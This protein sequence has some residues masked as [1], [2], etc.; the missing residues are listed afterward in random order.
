MI[1][2]YYNSTLNFSM[3]CDRMT[4]VLCI[5]CGAMFPKHTC[6]SENCEILAAGYRRHFRQMNVTP[7]EHYL[8][9]LIRRNIWYCGMHDFCKGHNCLELHTN[10]HGYN[11]YKYWS[12]D[13]HTLL[14]V[15]CMEKG[16]YYNIGCRTYAVVSNILHRGNNVVIYNVQGAVMVSESLCEN[17]CVSE[18]IKFRAKVYCKDDVTTGVSCDHAPT[19]EVNTLEGHHEL[20]V[21]PYIKKMFMA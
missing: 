5:A 7:P 3:Q 14:D 18:Q 1:F 13:D 8:E 11:I 2:F 4:G 9:K 6:N 15:T 21:Y 16:K 17:M 19:L 20:S 10:L 12:A